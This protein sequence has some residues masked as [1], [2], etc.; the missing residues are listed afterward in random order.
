MNTETVEF[1]AIK[2]QLAKGSAL[3][4][5]ATPGVRRE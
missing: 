4:I 3:D 5:P 1:A 2:L